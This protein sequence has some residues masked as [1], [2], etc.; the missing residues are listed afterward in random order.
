MATGRFYDRVRANKLLQPDTGFAG[1]AELG[2][3][4]PKNRD[5]AK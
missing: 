4:A 3:L 5:M 2:R 1:A